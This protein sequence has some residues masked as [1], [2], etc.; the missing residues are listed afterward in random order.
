MEIKL[1]AFSTL[2]FQTAPSKVKV[3]GDPDDTLIQS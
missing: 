1:V 3:R 2:L